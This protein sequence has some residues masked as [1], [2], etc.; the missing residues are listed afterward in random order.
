M[1]TPDIFIHPSLQRQITYGYGGHGATGNPQY[2]PTSSTRAAWELL[3]IFSET[4][5][6]KGKN[7]VDWISPGHVAPGERRLKVTALSADIL[8]FDF[9]GDAG[10][11]E[12]QERIDALFNYLDDR[13]LGYSGITSY[14][15]CTKSTPGHSRFRLAIVA[16]RTINTHEWD[17]VWG[18]WYGIL[19]SFGLEP[20]PQPR[21]MSSFF[22]RPSFPEGM[23]DKTWVRSAMSGA[24]FSVDEA[25]KDGVA[26]K[27]K[28]S[29]VTPAPKTKGEKKSS[30]SKTSRSG[31]TIGPK[32]PADTILEVDGVGQVAARSML[33]GTKLSGVKS[34]WR[35]GSTRGAVAW[36]SDTGEVSVWDGT[37]NEIRYMEGWVD[38]YLQPKTPGLSSF[39]R[40]KDVCAS[41]PTPT[42]TREGNLITCP[43]TPGVFLGDQLPDLSTL[44]PEGGFLFLDAPLGVGKTVYCQRQAKLVGRVLAVTDSVALTRAVSEAYACELYSDLAGD[45]TPTRLATTVHSI[46]R[47]SHVSIETSK[48]VL[49]L[50]SQ[51]LRWDLAVYDEAPGIRSSLH[52]RTSKVAGPQQTKESMLAHLVC[53][54]WAIISTADFNEDE[55]AWWKAAIL[56]RREDAQI[57]VAKREVVP[58]NRTIRLLASEVWDTTLA[59]DLDTN[60]TI[61]VG[62]TEVAYPEIMAT[63]LDTEQPDKAVFWVSS[64]NSM[65]PEIRAALAHPDQIIEE[66]EA[67]ICSPSIK[68]GLSWSAP[69]DRVYFRGTAELPARDMCQMIMRVRN[70]KD[71]VVR[72]M[73]SSRHGEWDT[74]PEWIRKVAL[75]LAKESQKGVD[76]TM[77][78]YLTDWKTGQRVPTDPE[79]LDSW[80]LTEQERRLNANDSL[81]EFLRACT[82]HGWT[83]LDSRDCKADEK[84]AKAVKA[85]TKAAKQKVDKTHCTDVLASPQLDDSEAEQLD[86]KAELM[87]SEQDSLTRHSI[88]E[89][90]GCPITETLVEL[91]NRG[92]KRSQV[93]DYT[94][95]RFWQAGVKATV[96]IKDQHAKDTVEYRH[97][98]L[99]MIMIDRI[100]RTALGTTLD[101]ADGQS[102]TARELGERIGPLLADSTFRSSIRE[103]LRS[104]VTEKTAEN[105]TQWICGVL[106]RL[107][108]ELTMTRPVN[109]EG[110]QVRTYTINLTQIRDLSR[111]EHSRTLRLLAEM[112]APS[113][114]EGRYTQTP[115]VTEALLASL[116]LA[117]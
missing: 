114:N 117:A 11:G 79:M 19:R 57:L 68:A 84:E 1:Q 77:I 37:A 94:S 100:I 113:L 39:L 29:R 9:D 99:R 76:A 32:L 58:G 75:G 115:E 111:A 98:G 51:E 47:F 3:R 64:R 101:Q 109:E 91:D 17:R 66:N 5:P 23:Q 48:G 40:E 103:V 96:L 65:R 88:E 46:A 95:L 22:Y 56:R 38:S 110:D 13:C 53:S 49:G 89:F 6:A 73:V 35:V 116:G 83:V 92:K 52:D 97:A 8:L 67:V 90:Y 80:T 63:K 43:A 18:Y 78:Q 86:R 20:D 28:T 31:T 85:S 61:V 44:L 27:K 14:S 41:F 42:Y 70:P 87:K 26:F 112:R 2:I 102:F 34:P 93:R 108:A 24:A 54:K 69:V 30:R 50:V 72:A 36:C 10:K 81:R 25:Y 45:P 16:D 33:P 74:R 82:R 15:H 12:P 105:P 59:A 21:Q 104:S 55:I 60:Q 71:T 106:R 4:Y 107:G 62:T 7:Q